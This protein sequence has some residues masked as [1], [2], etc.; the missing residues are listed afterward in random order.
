[1]VDPSVHRNHL[2]LFGSD[3]E[4]SSIGSDPGSSVDAA[5]RCIDGKP[6]RSR[7]RTRRPSINSAFNV[8]SLKNDKTLVKNNLETALSDSS[9]SPSYVTEK[10]ENKQLSKCP[11]TFPSSSFQGNP[12]PGKIIPDL[13]GI[14][15]PIRSRLSESSNSDREI[16]ALSKIDATPS[17]SFQPLAT[18]VGEVD[19]IDEKFRGLLGDKLTVKFKVTLPSPANDLLKGP[20]RFLRMPQF[21]PVESGPYDAQKYEDQMT[22][23]DL[24]DEQARG[25]FVN[26]MKTTVRW[27]I[28]KDQ[29]KES[30]ARLIRWSDGSETFHVGEEAF[31]VMHHPVTDDQNQMY[32]R[33]E[34]CYQTQGAITDKMTLRP[35]LDS[36]FGQTHVQGMRN[37]AMNRPQTGSVKILMDMGANPVKDRER[38]IKEEMAQLRREEREKRRDLQMSQRKPR[39]KPMHH[40]TADD[41]DEPNSDEADAISILAIKKAASQGIRTNRNVDIKPQEFK[42]VAGE[43][44]RANSYTEDE[45][46]FDDDALKDPKPST[47]KPRKDTES[48]SDDGPQLKSFKRKTKHVVYSDSSSD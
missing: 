27:R 11:N 20:Q 44:K 35:K 7:S 3:S 17:I 23:G 43:S 46:D 9:S 10:Q 1:M 39:I 24:K 45:L 19:P 22:P 14:Q 47:S 6:H 38:R 42:K 12:S 48:D 8:A 40:C 25:D 32:V 29:V 4:E 15:S 13:K 33:L 21:I 16:D 28:G 36:T 31:D 34:S 30:N 18:I 2:N 41:S 26:R 37:R 5:G